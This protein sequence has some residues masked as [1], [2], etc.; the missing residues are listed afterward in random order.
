VYKPRY[1]GEEIFFLLP[2][3]MG[4]LPFAVVKVIISLSTLL[5]VAAVND[6]GYSVEKYDASP[7]IY[8]ENIGVAVLY[9]NAW[10]AVVYVNLNRIANENVV[11][12]KYVQHVDTLFQ[13]TV[14]RN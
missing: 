4:D 11:L 7:G 2:F 1:K 14:I 12:R 13:M 3:R 9:N 5:T 8:Y 10:R 6:F